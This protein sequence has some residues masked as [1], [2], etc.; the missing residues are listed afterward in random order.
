VDHAY[1][2]ALTS[3]VVALV[4]DLIETRPVRRSV[5]VRED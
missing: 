2:F 3:F 5:A 1:V 4:L